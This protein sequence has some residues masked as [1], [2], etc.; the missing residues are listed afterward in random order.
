MYFLTGKVIKQ[1]DAQDATD[2]DVGNFIKSMEG[3]G[4]N[5]QTHFLVPPGTLI[6]DG[7]VLVEM[8]RDY[9]GNLR[10]GSIRALE[11]VQ[12]FLALRAILRHA[13]E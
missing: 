5:F 11:K 4:H 2:K 10:L 12:A 1:N 9:H 6:M 8:D 13:K 3:S 7:R